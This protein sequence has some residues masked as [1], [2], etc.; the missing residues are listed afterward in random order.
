MAALVII[1]SSRLEV[2]PRLLTIKPTSIP[3]YTSYD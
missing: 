1:D 3:V 2:P